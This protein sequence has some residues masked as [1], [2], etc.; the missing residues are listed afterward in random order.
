VKSAEIKMFDQRVVK[1][2]SKKSMILLLMALPFV[3]LVFMFNYVPLFG[4]I[5]AFFDYKPGIPLSSSPFVGLKFFELILHDG[6]DM[7]RVVKNTLAMGL[8]GIL[9]SPLPVIFAI[10]LNEVKHKYFRK[11]VQTAATF[12]NFISWVIVFSLSF[13]IFSSEGLFNGIMTSLGLIDKPTNLLG[14]ADAVWY[15]QT[16]LL[17]WKSLGWTSVIYLAAIT[18][19]DAEIYEAGKMDGASRLKLIWHVT[20]PGIMPTFIVLLLLSVSNILTIG[21]DQ[22]Y[23]F[24]NPLVADNI[25][26]L[27]LY[28]YR[29]GIATNDY[30]YATAIGIAKTFV[31]I[32]L[33][34]SVNL[35]AKKVRGQ[36][37]V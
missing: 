19:I 37:I 29:I 24:K 25:E 31:G 22:Y 5:Y 18:G 11:L 33:L 20:V 1:E 26:V 28:V 7:A 17:I 34:F 16:A 21:F 23:A 10:M 9:C 8:L 30:S 12:P 4:W 13:S 6:G 36:S 3:I 35:F 27:D 15:F 14:N 32:I 2:K